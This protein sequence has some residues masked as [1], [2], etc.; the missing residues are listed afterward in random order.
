[1]ST[2]CKECDLNVQDNKLEILVNQLKREVE[3]LIKDTNKTLLIHDGKIAELCKYIKENL[4]NSLRTLLDT[5]LETGELEQIIT[6]TLLNNVNEKVYYCNTH[7]DLKHGNYHVGDTIRTLG[8]SGINDNGGALYFIREYKTSDVIDDSFKTLMYNGNVAELITTDYINIACIKGDSLNE[9]F[10][11]LKQTQREYKYK[12]IIIPESNKNNSACYIYD[13]KAYWKVT[14]TIKIDDSLNCLE[15]EVSDRLIGI[16]NMK[17]MIE[18]YG[19]NKPENIRIT[20][21]LELL[22]LPNKVHINNGLHVKNSG[23]VFVESI[24][25]NYCDTG[26]FLGDNE[27][28]VVGCEFKANYVGVGYYSD[29]GFKASSSMSTSL[30]I[31]TLS[32][33]NPTKEN[34]MTMYLN[35]IITNSKISTMEIFRNIGQ[36]NNRGIFIRNT[37][38][39][40]LINLD[41]DYLVTDEG[42]SGLLDIQYC[43]LSINSLRT[44]TPVNTPI[45]LINNSICKIN[46]YISYNAP[47]L[48]LDNTCK[49]VINSDVAQIENVNGNV[50]VNGFAGNENVNNHI[51][52]DKKTGELKYRINGVTKTPLMNVFYKVI[53]D[54]AELPTANWELRGKL[55]YLQ[56]S[57]TN[58]DI[59]Y[60]C[61]RSSNSGYY[62]KPISLT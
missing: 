55:I 38:N 11:T 3:S 60:V 37:Y 36:P 52:L 49:I 4:S 7:E 47:K 43:Y 24:L 22:A 8:Y 28:T 53:S 33:Q 48:T 14:D 18:I 21:F 45:I 2:I 6:E 61:M 30:K 34:V 1:M 27:S 13:D 51:Y 56:A 23:R 15:I 50:I 19:K 29:C 35:G 62:W 41:I 58:D 20:G 9:K 31:D 57:G 32:I 44:S 10:E 46:N 5:M 42:L 39:N 16:N 12:K 17:S 40:R 26:I 25:V 54:S 59:I